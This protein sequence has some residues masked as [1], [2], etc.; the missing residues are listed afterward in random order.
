LDFFLISESFFA[1]VDDSKILPGYKTDHSLVLLKF[2]F[3]KFKKG[4]SYWKFNNALLKDYKFVEEIKKVITETKQLYTLDNQTSRHNI[5]D[6]HSSELTLSISDQLFYDV[7]LMEIRGKTISYASFKKRQGE[8]KETKLME[9][10]EKI[11]KHLNINHELLDS[12]R[13][14]LYEIRQKKLEGV[15]MRSKAKW[16]DDGEKVTKYFCNLENRNFVSKCMNSLKKE[17]GDIIKDHLEILNE[18]MLFY[19]QLY[20]KK[21]VNEF[22]LNNLCSE[23]NV[24]KIEGNDKMHLDGLI[25]Y[26]ELLD[27]LKKTSNN[28]SPG[29]D[30]FTYEFFKF[31]WRDLGHFMLRAINESYIKGELSESL[32]RGV[33]TCIPKGNKDKLMLK[34]WRP[35]SLLNTSYKLA[36]SCIA[37]RLKKVLS[38]I[39]NEDQTGFIA[40][41]YIGE[42]I[43][44][45]YD[46][47]NHTEKHQIP[48]MLLLI[49]FE[50]AFDSVSWDFL[51][52]VLDFF[53]F[54]RSFKKWVR[55]FY[56]NIQSC[57][58]VNGH[59]SDWFYPQRG[60]R[61]GDPLSPYLFILC[62]EI[63]AIMLRNDRN[64]TGIKIGNSELLVSQYADDTSIM[65]D[66]SQQSLE[67]CL[68]VLKFYAEASGLFVNIDKTKVVWIGSKKN[69][70][71]K[72]CEEYNLCWERNE[73]TVLGVTFPK[74]LQDIVEVNYLTKIEEM[75]K[76]FLNWSKR[77]LT[78]LGKIVVIKSLALSKINHL[79]L[80][81][82]NPSEK[83]VKDIQNMFYDYLW[84]HGPDK[85]KRKLITQNYDIGGLR[86]IDLSL[87]IHSL[88]LTWLRRFM[89]NINK[90]SF[91]VQ[92]LYPVIYDCSRFGGK[93]FDVRK[94]QINNKFW[95][96][97]LYSYKY[98]SESVSPVNWFEC[99]STPIW[100]NN[101][102]KV[103][104][105]AVFYQNWT[106]KGIFLI[107]DLLDRNGNLISFEVFQR[108]FSI[109]SNFLQF[110]GLI[111]SVRNCLHNFRVEHFPNRDNNPVLPLVIRYILKNKKGCRNI[112]DKL[113]YKRINPPS[114]FKWQNELNLSPEFEWKYIFGLPFRITKDT[115]LKWLQVRINHR[116]LGT[117]YLLAK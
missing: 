115:S 108:E 102:I 88:K 27:C 79:I 4:R 107:N 71:D 72:F 16:I 59:L 85:I 92:E 39:I 50:K 5:N 104:G 109:R 58:I 29:F 75:K 40:G 83:L 73:F 31:F 13:K 91:I 53:N 81:I 117:N 110:E 45:L 68:K 70:N 12:K 89:V 17:N 38:K 94:H 76:I 52:K 54:G 65:L 64:I 112:Y 69:S 20:S 1:D 8:N 42:N 43:R 22:D 116:I 34:N 100:Y 78:P 48:G 30:G 36:S 46:V 84:A 37:E 14:E 51:F 24:P 62:A 11:E 82:P 86:M 9:E 60:C 32:T 35:I 77:I 98:F 93:I 90:Y 87:F 74:N 99:V 49:D 6:I 18:T 66:G 57:V 7:L 2:D 21:N 33:I 114:T 96:E 26:Q 67:N 61:Q 95:E 80:A 63:L 56:T 10:I 103:G 106:E 97:V 113:I 55:V 3:G 25:T 23:F 28:T 19:K 47:I 41:R 111:S 44:L 15:K 101:S 105:S